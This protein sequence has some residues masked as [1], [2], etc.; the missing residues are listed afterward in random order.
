MCILHF[1]TFRHRFIFFGDTRAKPQ[2]RFACGAVREGAP[3]IDMASG[4]Q[5]WTSSP[6][7]SSDGAQAAF[8][9][10]SWS[11]S[12]PGVKSASVQPCFAAH[13]LRTFAV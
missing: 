11:K 3:H 10:G 4:T 1:R 7:T 13:Y 12:S 5:G 6:R 2:F 8:A 9:F